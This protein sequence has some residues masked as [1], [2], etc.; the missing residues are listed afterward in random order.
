MTRYHAGGLHLLLLGGLGACSPGASGSAPVATVDV[1]PV[2]SSRS[3]APPAE[4]EA[5][6]R[7]TVLPAMDAAERLVAEGRAYA[8]RAEYPAALNRF[9]TAYRI[10]PSDRVL[11]HIGQTLELMGRRGEAAEVYEKYL[12]SDLSHMDRMTME[13]RIKQLRS[14]P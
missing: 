10:S 13:L 6:A 8:E 4:V 7:P 5:G 11:Y 1:K 2:P 12:Q 3:A 9:E 14:A